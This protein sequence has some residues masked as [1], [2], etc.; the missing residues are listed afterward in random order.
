MNILFV[1]NLYPT[2]DTHNRIN[3]PFALHYFAKEWAK[4]NNVQVIVPTVKLPN[5]LKHFPVVS[6]QDKFVYCT[7]Y[8]LDNVPIYRVGIKKYPKYKYSYKSIGEQSCKIIRY[9]EQKDFIPDVIIA[10]M[11]EPAIYISVNL[12]EYY[13]KELVLCFHDY[14]YNT[15]L[16]KKY[17]KSDFLKLRNKIDKFAY[18][19]GVLYRKMSNEYDFLKSDNPIIVPSGIDSSIAINMEQKLSNSSRCDKIRL[20]TIARLVKGKNIDNIINSVEYLISKYKNVEL[21]IVG[22]GD[23]R[24]KLEKMCKEKGIQEYVKFIGAIPRKQIFKILLDKDIFLLTSSPETF[25]LVYLEAM[26]QGCITV[27]SK[28]EG[29]SD[30]I[31]NGVNGFLCTPN[32][33]Q[34]LNITIEKIINLNCDDKKEI[35]NNALITVKKYDESTIYMNYLSDVLKKSGENEK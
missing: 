16:N 8:N 14:D 11:L 25:G 29:I 1:T 33:Q 32:N 19:S 26:S 5:I 31:N 35:I 4:Q 17:I 34:E 2:S 28:G 20:V 18:R 21:T 27:G 10:H 3:V 23:E 9:L 6:D 15:S 22:D 24:E 30:V 12:K 7:E 13:K